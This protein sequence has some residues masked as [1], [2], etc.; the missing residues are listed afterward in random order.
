M[1][2][3]VA[4]I[5]KLKQKASKDFEELLCKVELGYSPDYQFI[6]EEL[7][8]LRHHD[9]CDIDS[10]LHDYILNFYLNNEWQTM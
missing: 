5:T 6:L 2:M 9:D 8:F 1:T 3:G 4:A 7:M 10:S